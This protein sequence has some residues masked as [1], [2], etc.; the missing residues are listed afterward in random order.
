MALS[1]CASEGAQP[2]PS[3]GNVKSSPLDEWL[4]I[5][6]M[7]GTTPEEIQRQIEARE[8]RQDELLAMCMHEAGFQYA[9]VNPY[10][11]P[12]TGQDLALLARVEAYGNNMSEA[13]FEAWWEAYWG[14][15]DYPDYDGYER[16][17]EWRGCIGWADYTVNNETVFPEFM[18]E[19]QWLF[20]ARTQL[21]ESIMQ[22]PTFVELN[23]EWA[24]CMATAGFPGLQFA[25]TFQTPESAL[26]DQDSADLNC[27]IETN[28]L[29]R[30]TE[31]VFTAENQ[32][33]EQH[34]ADLEAFRLA[35]EQQ[36]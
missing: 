21:D 19:F 3:S 12:P 26:T 24:Y 1:G 36:G 30:A 14:P 6:W 8:R 13:E 34:R 18:A 23:S 22:S 32:F 27:Q 25:E 10:T 5:E 4:H 31:I 28:Y 15:A 11:E 2:E 7:A 16:P 35:A 17:L 9:P 29:E 20:D 33:I